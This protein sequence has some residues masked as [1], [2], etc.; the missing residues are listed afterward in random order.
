MPPLS[1]N[2]YLTCRRDGSPI[3]AQALALC[4]SNKARDLLSFFVAARLQVLPLSIS[5]EG[6]VVALPLEEALHDDDSLAKALRF[7]IERPIK[8]VFVKRQILKRAIFIAYHLDD[9]ELIA[10]SQ[11]L[12]TNRSN[13]S[14]SVEN[15]FKHLLNF[16]I[17][18]EASDIY[19]EPNEVA[20]SCS[21]RVKGELIRSKESLCNSHY[22]NELIRLIKVKA[23]LPISPSIHPLDGS[24]VITTDSYHHSV[25]V[26]IMPTTV[27]EKVVLRILGNDELLT[28]R[29]LSLQLELQ[30]RLRSFIRSANGLL[31]IS[32]PTG[33]GKT[34]TL[35]ALL[36]DLAEEG[37]N[38]LTI[39]DPVERS[40]GGVTQISVAPPHL[41][42]E[43][44]FKGA[45]R[46]DPDV[47][48][49]GEIRD[50]V[51]ARGVI[52]ASLTG[53]L[54]LSTIHG[55]SIAQVL[56]RL[57]M[58]L[59]ESDM[60]SSFEALRGIIC[61]RLLPRLCTHCKV[62]DNRLS[63]SF[64]FKVFQRKGCVYCNFTG[65]SGRALVI[66]LVNFHD[67]AREELR[68]NFPDYEAM[69]RCAP[70]A[71]LLFE[72]SVMRLFREG[73]IDGEVS[74]F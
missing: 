24:F 43:I 73:V 7:A 9:K 31:L 33:S 35:Y 68:R 53:H 57:K 11:E 60:T 72:E 42:Y 18:S 74:S 49:I 56:E 61:Q 64:G 63:N 62:Q 10:T 20:T 23:L 67:R 38:I 55:G 51:A 65:V 2:L 1:E 30:E 47:V 50:G 15:L 71:F 66:E 12:S 41:T 29:D 26:S 58:L 28:L 45:L 37:R 19:I 54:I 40:I 14:T 25:R 21:L 6:V 3:G 70:Q 48:M 39:E 52:E 32:G 4:S 69:L 46:Q 44:A 27:G 13:L 36:A 8:R 5:E 17:A 34:T 16:A 59:T 22:H